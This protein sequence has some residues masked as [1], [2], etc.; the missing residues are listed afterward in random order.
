MP[1][2]P[3]VETVRRGLERRVLGRTITKVAI[4]GPHV[5]RGDVRRFARGI[6]GGRVSNLRRKGKTLALELI[7]A[8]SRPS[9]Y[10][11][12]RLGM[13]GQLVVA[14]RSDAV[15]PHTHVHMA[16]DDGDEELRYR[17]P[18]RFGMLRFCTA[19]EAERAF[20]LLGPDALEMT[21]A[22]FE[23]AIAGRRGAV[24]SWLM[25][26]RVLA[27]LGNIYA[28]EALFEARIHPETPAGNIRKAARQ[29]LFSAIRSVLRHAVSLQGTSFRDYID[30]EG[31]PGGFEPQLRAYQ[32]TGAPCPRCGALIRRVVVSGRSSHYC[33]RCQRKRALQ[34]PTR[35]QH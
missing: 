18:R 1:E 16:L 14:W 15:P 31:R 34:H 20:G 24:K 6:E 7:F 35:S 25:N 28:D 30:I 27:G 29:R 13:T 10:L 4:A 12:I 23:R 11:L 26:Q 5:V 3:E 2:L 9:A 21:E 33:P 19:A 22:E 17:D 32:R 8:D